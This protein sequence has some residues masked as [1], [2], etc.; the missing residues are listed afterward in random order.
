M[1]IICSVGGMSILCSL[2]CKRFIEIPCKE[3]P[4]S[5]APPEVDAICAYHSDPSR[6]APLVECVEW[7]RFKIAKLLRDYAKIR[8][9]ELSRESPVV[10]PSNCS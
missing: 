6:C 1:S 9:V 2:I 8:A 4:F 7:Y 10:Q 5:C 3:W